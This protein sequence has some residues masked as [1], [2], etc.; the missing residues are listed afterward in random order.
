MMNLVFLNKYLKENYDLDVPDR[1]ESVED[2][3]VTSANMWEFA[4]LKNEEKALFES[5][6]EALA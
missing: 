2:F 6:K 1:P 5:I 4:Q 3:S